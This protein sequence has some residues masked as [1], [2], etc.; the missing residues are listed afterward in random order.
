ME[1]KS[2]DASIE[3]KTDF[4]DGETATLQLTLKTDKALTISLRRPQ[5]AGDGFD[6]KVNGEGIA[7]MPPPDSYVDIQRAWK[8]GDKISLTLPKALHEEA[9]P[10]NKRRV[11]MMWG[12]LVLA[13]DMGT[14]QR[15]GGY[16]NRSENDE[17]VPVFVAADK[18]MTDWMKPV[19]GQAG[20]FETEGVGEPTNVTFV[21][22]YEL[23]ERTYGIYWD[24]YTPDEWTKE[25]ARIAAEKE[26]QHKLQLATVAY[27]HPGLMQSERDY[28]EQGENSEPT[29][30]MGRR[31]RHGR[32]WFSFDLPV[33]TN[34]PMAVVVT[35]Y[36]DEWRKR[37]FDVLVNG[38]KVGHQ[39]VEK[40]GEP[41]FFDVEYE[42]PASAIG[43]KEKATVKFQATDGNEIAAVFGIR[44]V[45]ADAEK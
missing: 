38:E 28:N 16:G 41:H 39:V 2:E 8:S 22:F 36:S 29:R 9:L 40:G 42:A 43:G 37:T 1:G 5:W 6:V 14:E 27:A 11:A 20:K 21:P 31:G 10:D 15:R 34:H 26:R 33:E 44:M 45:R 24:V 3:V 19:A 7:T 17:G 18:P 13:G 4:P 12:P 32:D 30:V 23:P 25:S 35:Y